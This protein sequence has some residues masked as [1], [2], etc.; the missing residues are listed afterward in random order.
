MEGGVCLKK[1]VLLIS[2]AQISMWLLLYVFN[3]VDLN[4]PGKDIITIGIVI[5]MILLVAGTIMFLSQIDTGKTGKLSTQLSY[6]VSYLILWY[7]ETV[8]LYSFVKWLLRHNFIITQPGISAGVEYSL[9]NTY[10]YII[11]I[12]VMLV[13]YCLI[14]L[15]VSCRELKDRKDTIRKLVIMTVIHIGIWLGFYVTN[16]ISIGNTI[17]EW[18]EEVRSVLIILIIVFGIKKIMSGTDTSWNGEID[19]QLSYPIPYWGL[20]VIEVIGIILFFNFM[21]ENNWIKIQPEF[22]IFGN[23]YKYL[24]FFLF[25]IP[26]V[27]I[28][29]YDIKVWINSL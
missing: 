15:K 27:A 28:L 13:Y 24:A 21:I 11:P 12:L 10:A 2:G 29:V 23:E 8:L 7:I 4:T 5:I 16:S 25:V 17:W 19:E 20:W 6:P 14:M 9:I 22:D 1:N 3:I 26:T 18:T